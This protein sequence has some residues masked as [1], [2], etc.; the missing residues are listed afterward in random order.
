MSEYGKQGLGI[1]GRL[2]RAF[3]RSPLT[4]LMILASLAVGMVALVSLPREEEPQISVPMVDIHIQAPGLRA[5][6]AVK[7]VTE[8]METIVKAINGVEHVYSQSMDDYAMVTARFLVGTS[9]DAAILRVHDKVRANFDRIPVG[10]AEPLIVGRGI[11]DV[12]IVALTLSP[13]PGAEAMTANDLTRVARQLQVEMAKIQ[14]VGLTYLVGESPEAI[15]IAPDPD[16]LAL[17]GV[18]LQQLSGKVEA[19]NHA[20]A[21]GTVRD[22]GEQ[23]PLVAGETLRAPAEIGNLLLTARDGRPVYVRDVADISFIADSSDK[24]VSNLTRDADGTIRRTPAVTLAVAKRAGANAVVVAEQVLHRVHL[25]EDSLIPESV[26]VEITRD[27]GETANEKAN[28]LLFHLGLATVS[29]VALVLFAIGWRE[30]IVVAVVI[31]V[32]ILL[33][34]FAAWIMGYTLNRVSLFALIFSIGILVDDAIVM[35]ENISRHWGMPDKA[36]RATKAIR[37]VAEVGN[38]TIVATMTVVAALLPML[39]VSGMMGPYMSPIPANASAAM[40]FSFFVAVIIT[41]WLMLKIAGGAPVHHDAAGSPGGR[42][43]KIYTAVARPLLK[44]RMRSGL[45]LLIT[46][47]LSFGSMVAFYTKDVTVK[48]LPFDNKSELAVMI[49]LPE[50]ASVEA[51]DAVAQDVARAVLELPEVI[52]IQT[53]AGATAPFNFNGLVRHYYLRERAELGDVQIN[54]LPKGDRDR[55]SH[56]IALDIRARITALDVPAGTSL[57]TVEPPPGPPVMATLLAEVYGPDA[58]TRR[59]AARQIRTAF[60]EVPFIVDVDDSFGEQSR[61]LRVTINSDQMEFF[62]VQESDVFSTVAILNGGTTVGY[63]HRGE[64]RRPIPIRVERD[65]A[66]RVV[67]ERFLTTP[68]PANVLPG[69]R[70][71]VELGDVVSIREERASFPI[72]RHNGRAAEMVLGEL[73]GSFEAPLYGML[74]VDEALD[75]QDW[76]EG[77]KPTVS[78]HGQPEDESHVT[79]LWDGEWEVTWVTFRDMGAAFAV[80]LLAIY[81]LVVAQFGSFR[82]PLVILT[83][84]PLTFLGIIGGHW[85][86]SAPFSATSM[87]G[88]IALAGIIVRNSILL[89]DFIRHEGGP[90]TPLVETLIAAGA[91]RFKPI[92]LTAIAAMIGA[93]VILA[94]PIFQGLAISLLFGLLSSTL[95]TVLVIPAIYRVFKD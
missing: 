20:F 58:D 19:A 59:K 10:I 65:K 22:G 23:I 52:S 72:Y 86:F 11:D 13:K 8:P 56:D 83:P 95:L 14:D 39:F 31:P 43:G 60:E 61:R 12:A 94:D 25:L 36:D 84:I 79:L 53:H 32:T 26:A 63:S 27:Y 16:R 90:D 29:I 89:V 67:D 81:I 35:I 64:G 71:V 7:L 40:I 9:A 6:G 47:G 74:A 42:L 70:G 78:L 18:T 4:P 88:F 92:L 73:A 3:I 28:E 2:T 68:I 69:A 57:K 30:S 54:L 87:I 77:T 80:A 21:A 50:G 17:F 1:A 44:T 66:D 75:R 62:G 37:A 41:P 51:T 76:A 33:T 55:T 45:F 85:L 5:E 34:L 38:P 49:D 93:V 91:I 46:A 48:L 15:R 82:L 24:I